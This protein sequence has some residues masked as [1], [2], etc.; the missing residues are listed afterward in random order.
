MNK[1]IGVFLHTIWVKKKIDSWGMNIA[2]T[3][4]IGI[5]IQD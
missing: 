5:F 1:L 3:A 2:P 4:E